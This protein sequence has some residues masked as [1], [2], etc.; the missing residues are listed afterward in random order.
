MSFRERGADPTDDLRNGQGL[1]FEHRLKIVVRPEDKTFGARLRNLGSA[2]L[3]GA[4]Y[5]VLTSRGR[6]L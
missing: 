3:S 6:G 5:P 4:S 2:V 1:A